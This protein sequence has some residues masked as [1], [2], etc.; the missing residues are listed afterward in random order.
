MADPTEFYF[1][2]RIKLGL[3]ADR[4]YRYC[5]ANL[6]FVRFEEQL[7]DDGLDTSF[8]SEMVYRVFP[9]A[10][11][12]NNRLGRRFFRLVV[13][14]LCTLSRNPDFVAKLKDSLAVFQPGVLQGMYIWTS[15]PLH[16]LTKIVW[17][18]TIM[19]K[20]A[21]KETNP[22]EVIE[23]LSVAERGINYCQSGN[24]AVLTTALMKRMWFSHNLLEN[25]MP[26]FNRLVKVSPQMLLQVQMDNW[27]MDKQG[28]PL[29]S[30]A[31]SMKHTYGNSGLRGY[32]GIFRVR[33]ATKVIPSDFMKHLADPERTIRFM[34]DTFFS[35]WVSDMQSMV[36]GAVVS[37]AQAVIDAEESADAVRWAKH[38]Q[39]H[40]KLFL[41]SEKLFS[42]HR[43]I[44]VRYLLDMIASTPGCVPVVLP[45]S[46][47][48]HLSLPGFARL[49]LSMYN[50]EDG[51]TLNKSPL[52]PR[53]KFGSTWVF[54][55][56]MRHCYAVLP[57]NDNSRA[58]LVKTVMAA[59]ANLKVNFFPD[60]PPRPA[61]G[62]PHVWQSAYH[63]TLLNVAPSS[64]ER[65]LLQAAATT[66]ALAQQLQTQQELVANVNAE[67]S[68]SDA[69]PTEF[70]RYLDKTCP[71][72]ELA[73]AHIAK[74][75]GPFEGDVELYYK[76]ACGYF[77]T[78][79]F[80]VFCQ[81]STWA[82]YFLSLAAP[83]V[84]RQNQGAIPK[85]GL[86]GSKEI[87]RAVRNAE[88]VTRPAHK[89]TSVPAH[90]FPMAAV[91]FLLLIHPQS[92]LMAKFKRE[93][94]FGTDF[95]SKHSKF[96][97][98]RTYPELTPHSADHKGLMPFNAIRMG[99]ATALSQAVLN[100]CLPGTAYAT[101]TEPQLKLYVADIR[102]R[103]VHREDLSKPNTFGPFSAL[104]HFFGRDM[105]LELAQLH[106]CPVPVTAQPGAQ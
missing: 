28:Y 25:G 55:H 35:S 53:D 17:K 99:L 8:R 30:V 59:V 93:N 48:K 2:N 51:K 62:R 83:K 96:F 58:L 16:C 105:G 46:E 13:T 78:N 106:Q 97:S 10:L 33:V 37:D 60:V 56:V 24:G 29:T 52:L 72:S 70:F 50:P 22:H 79:Y 81:A 77:V 5:E 11:R 69:R 89:V 49:L 64:E 68:I 45:Q 42:Y 76:W 74:Q 71:P 19:P 63:W 40:A 91:Y 15:Y 34:M 12:A 31:S 92:P 103:L 75:N 86:T 14:P 9:Q 20:Y 95:T 39:A 102:H 73:F 65:R 18:N 44:G 80:D 88:W 101:L 54:Q 87:T 21:S 43:D 67:W 61:T 47:T 104:T 6:P 23:I 41:T 4:L 100:K 7:K 84:F 1:L 94:K 36:Y 90:Y 26:M 85:H 82:A 3:T 98:Q 27:P 38:R 32:L 57:Q 66:P